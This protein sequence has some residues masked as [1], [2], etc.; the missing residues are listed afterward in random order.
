MVGEL[1]VPESESEQKDI[2]INVEVDFNT[3][4]IM[5]IYNYDELVKITSLFNV[6][7]AVLKLC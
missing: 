2:P 1:A 3:R 7:K 6:P 4:V 5:T